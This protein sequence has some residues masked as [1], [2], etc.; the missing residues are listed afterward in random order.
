MKK[1]LQHLSHVPRVAR[2]LPLALLAGCPA[3]TED[4]KGHDHNSHGHE[5][6]EE[7]GELRGGEST[8]SHDGHDHG[9]EGGK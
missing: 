7:P 3:T 2:V 8:E 9:E 6:G 5:V 1:L 4:H